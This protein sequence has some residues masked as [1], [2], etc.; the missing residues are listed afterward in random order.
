M[1]EFSE[2]P[3]SWKTISE[4]VTGNVPVSEVDAL[5]MSY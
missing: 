3:T 5:M 2:K 1:V 4:P